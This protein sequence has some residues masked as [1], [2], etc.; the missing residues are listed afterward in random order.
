MTVKVSEIETGLARVSSSLFGHEC[1]GEK[2]FGLGKDRRGGRVD[3]LDIVG[4]SGKVSSL[5]LGHGF[6]AYTYVCL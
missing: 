2:V 4:R 3:G 1:G 6:S 5:P